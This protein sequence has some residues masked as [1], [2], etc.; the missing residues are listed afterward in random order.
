[1]V[2]GLTSRQRQV[3]NLIVRYIK[4]RGYPPTLRELQADLDIGTPRGVLTHVKALERKGYLRRDS[5]PRGIQ[6]LREADEKLDD[7]VV[8]LPLVGRVPAGTPIL[9][10]ENV[11]EW[12]P[13]P[14]R[15]LPKR[16][17]PFVLRVDGDSMSGDNIQT[18][19]LLLVVPEPKAQSTP[20][21]IVVALHHGE[22]T[23][24]RLAKQDTLLVLQPSN[25]THDTIEVDEGTSIQGKVIGRIPVLR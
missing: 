2:K 4:G 1:M 15:L 5:T 10:D 13:W 7:D 23:V 3:L 11:E 12:I 6:V 22:V 14:R 20:G 8:Y 25:P 18:G 19:D 21:D 24:K 9:A 16:T 17:D